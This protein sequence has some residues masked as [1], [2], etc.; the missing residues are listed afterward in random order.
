ML[1]GRV[2][3][4]RGI[5]S[6]DDDIPWPV[7]NSTVT[8]RVAVI[9]NVAYV[10]L[11]L[12]AV[13]VASAAYGRPNLILGLL[14][15][16]FAVVAS[17]VDVTRASKGLYGRVAKRAV[18]LPAAGSLV[19]LFRSG[20]GPMPA[21]VAVVISGLV[22]AGIAMGMLVACAAISRATVFGSTAA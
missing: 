13:M 5:V 8:I 21:S 20:V 10:V 6:P 11:A 9:A 19:V 12:S 7:L 22:T 17:A 15:G 18:W 4:R 14:V 16:L 1:A 3:L 2:C